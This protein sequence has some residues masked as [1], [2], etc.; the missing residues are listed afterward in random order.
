MPIL[1]HG[2]GEIDALAGIEY[3]NRIYTGIEEHIINDN[4][5]TIY[6]INGLKVDNI[7]HPGIYIISNGKNRKKVLIT[8]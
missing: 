6:D 7:K 2:W 4:I 3:I 1:V 5:K 8:K